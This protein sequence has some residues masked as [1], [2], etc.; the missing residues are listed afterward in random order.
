MREFLK[1]RACLAHGCAVILKHNL[2]RCITYSIILSGEGMMISI[3]DIILFLCFVTLFVLHR[4]HVTQRRNRDSISGVEKIAHEMQSTVEQK[5]RAIEALAIEANAVER[6][7]AGIFKE[8]ASTAELMQ[9]MHGEMRAEKLRIEQLSKKN[10][11]FLDVV[12]QARSMQENLQ[13]IIAHA[14]GVSAGMA[15]KISQA[16]SVLEQCDVREVHL[17]EKL[18]RLEDQMHSVIESGKDTMRSL[19]GDIASQVDATMER[20]DYKFKTYEEQYIEKI[21]VTL[22]QC[23]T[24][25]EEETEHASQST[26]TQFQKYIS[27]IEEHK[28]EYSAFVDSQK[29]TIATLKADTLSDLE[30]AISRKHDELANALSA[31]EQ[32]LEGSMNT[33]RD[34]Y[35]RE[36]LEVKQS[37]L[38]ISIMVEKL[39]NDTQRTCTQI[40]EQYANLRASTA[41]ELEAVSS[42]QALLTGEVTKTEEE[43]LALRENI[44]N[45]FEST[46]AEQQE[47]WNEK[48]QSYE[49]QLKESITKHEEQA[50]VLNAAHEEVV[51]S[52]EQKYKNAQE[53]LEAELHK[54]Q[55]GIVA[56]RERAQQV[57]ES[58]S[59]E[60]Q[61]V[62]NEKLQSYEAQ[63]EE[64]ITKHEEQAESLNAAH[65]EIVRSMEQKYKNAQEELEAELYKAQEDI[66]ALRESA[67]QALQSTSEEQQAVWNEKLQSYEAQLEESITKH[68]EQ[69]EALKAVHEKTLRDVSHACEE[70][71]RVTLETM[72]TTITQGVDNSVEDVSSFATEYFNAKKDELEKTMQQLQ[73]EHKESIHKVLHQYKTLCDDVQMQ[74]EQRDEYIEQKHTQCLQKMDELES[75]LQTRLESHAKII[76]ERADADVLRVVEHVNTSLDTV[77]KSVDSTQDTMQQKLSS[78][79][80]HFDSSEEAIE[81]KLQ[82]IQRLVQV[83]QEKH[84]K[85]VAL[86]D[87]DNESI[88]LLEKLHLDIEKDFAKTESA[89]VGLKTKYAASEKLE[90]KLSSITK[91]VD[92]LHEVL[93]SVKSKDLELRRIIKDHEK[94]SKQVDK[95]DVRSGKIH[96][97]IELLQSKEEK[98]RRIKESLTEIQITQKDIEKHKRDLENDK[99]QYQIVLDSMN[100]LE[101]SIGTLEKKSNLLQNN[102]NNWEGQI[103]ETGQALEAITQHK[104][105]V[106]NIAAR[107]DATKSNIPEIVRKLSEI[108]DEQ[109]RVAELETRLQKL[110]EEA[111]N[112]LTLLA[113]VTTPP[114]RKGKTTKIDEKTKDIIIGLN[115][116]SFK[117]ERIAKIVGISTNEVQMVLENMFIK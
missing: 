25:F 94:M 35:D 107:V 101:R 109:G 33:I 49:A 57:L 53:E 38:P 56:L 21:R 29:L 85:Q 1:P 113:L 37:V 32:T 5:Q 115:E 88:K 40:Q 117:P 83:L 93:A 65:E 34:K 11:Q 43:L 89:I 71:K 62:W 82:S 63:L 48:L 111:A 12:P 45:A 90:K 46:S 39:E 14:D 2:I 70:E 36:I 108:K 64:N 42:Q 79:Q 6:N 24:S 110:N 30:G 73:E 84:K 54:A 66:V 31:F 18:G 98:V 77:K 20:T 26:L 106:Q 76:E 44:Y 28:K 86:I 47:M 87:E 58:T 55:E 3:F 16:Q 96:D 68:E 15:S 69:A 103:H 52:M 19:V 7:V 10:K 81:H 99:A 22:E 100:A 17:N 59:E 104:E 4:V 67:Q 9:K 51:R 97:T 114:S 75:A 41:Q 91:Q 74:Y 78:M 102:M 50:E 13:S 61:A 27:G 95:I 60:Q 105:E 92:A 112:K 80:E 23:R 116:N 72:R 8:I